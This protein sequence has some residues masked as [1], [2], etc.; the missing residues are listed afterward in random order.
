MNFGGPTWLSCLHFPKVGPEYLVAKIEDSLVER[1][2]IRIPNSF[3]VW[4][5]VVNG[6][7][8]KGVLEVRK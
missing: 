6:E 5:L 8:I 4:L 2:W 3:M 7:K 1:E